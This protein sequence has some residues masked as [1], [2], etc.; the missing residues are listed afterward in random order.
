LRPGASTAAL[1]H[2][3]GNPVVPRQWEETKKAAQALGIEA[4]LLTAEEIIE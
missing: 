2:N 1:P 4:I 3:T